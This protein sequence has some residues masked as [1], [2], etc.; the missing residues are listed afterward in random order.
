LGDTFR[1]SC[2][3][4]V[5][6]AVQEGD[7]EK[8]AKQQDKRALNRIRPIYVPLRYIRSSLERNKMCK[9]FIRICEEPYLAS[10]KN[11]QDDEKRKNEKERGL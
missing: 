3:E 6:K 2:P 5:E 4:E 1:E 8:R 10:M 7:W 11:R 9:S